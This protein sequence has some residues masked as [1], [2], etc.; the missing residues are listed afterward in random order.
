MTQ[1]KIKLDRVLIVD[2]D[3][4]ILFTLEDILRKKYAVEIAHNGKEALEVITENSNQF[5]LIVLDLMMPEMNGFD[6]L[7]KIKNLD[8]PVL[9]LSALNDPSSKMIIMELGAWGYA[10]KPFHK[11]VLL[12]QIRNLI[13]LG[14]SKKLDRMRKNFAESKVAE[15]KTSLSKSH[16]EFK[17]LESKLLA[18]KM[19]KKNLNKDSVFQDVIESQKSI[20]N[21]LDTQLKELITVIKF[22]FPDSGAIGL[23]EQ[24][25]S[26]DQLLMELYDIVD[27]LTIHKMY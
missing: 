1:N 8:I 7:K 16:K 15:L 13:S 25:E 9:I 14:Q 3:E 22:Y 24:I 21:L 26:M 4:N 23:E 6:F 19:G 17:D 27:S 5:D 11:D 20:I 2:D 12:S 18:H 10:S